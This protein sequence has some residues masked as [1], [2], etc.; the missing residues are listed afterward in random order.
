ML[1]DGI[2][3]SIFIRELKPIDVDVISNIGI[4]LSIFIRE[5][6]LEEAW[7]MFRMV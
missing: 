3:L 2:S 4:S 1:R 6:K 5:L 7:E